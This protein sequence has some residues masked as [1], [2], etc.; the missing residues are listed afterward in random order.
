MQSKLVNFIFRDLNLV[1]ETLRLDKLNIIGIFMILFAIFLFIT[2]YL[3]HIILTITYP[4]LEGSSK[5][6]SVL[7]FAIMGSILLFYPLL[8]ENGTIA[9]KISSLS[10]KLSFN[11]QKCLKFTI[12]ILFSTYLF[13]IF[14][15]IWLRAKFGVSPFTMFVSFNSNASSTSIIHTHV[16]KSILG[17]LIHVLGIYVPSDIN[18]GYSIAEYVPQVAFAICIM[19]PLVYIAGLISLNIKK[20]LYKVILAF[21]FTTS[22]IGMLDGGLFSTPALVGLSC[23]LGIYFI[24]EPFMIR[25]LIKPSTIIIILILV[26]LLIGLL[27]NSADFH[28]ITI[29]HPSDNIDFT[30]YDV[31]SIEKYSDRMIVK[32]PGNINDKTLLLKLI[33]DLKGKC[34]GFFLSWNLFSWT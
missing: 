29:I 2:P 18:T 32:V 25:D 11:G 12:I 16:F 19:F 9:N 14:L 33:E 31:I 3:D 23:I 26:R 28:E 5:G 1:G 22:L 7:L 15:E 21:A 20:D 10:P 24:K 8:K 34:N 6:K 27:G 13:G 30:G 17:S 4:F